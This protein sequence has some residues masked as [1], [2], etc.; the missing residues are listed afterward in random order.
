MALPVLIIDIGRDSVRGGVF[1]PKMEPLDFFTEP[2]QGA[3]HADRVAGGV[4]EAA[5]LLLQKVRVKYKGFEKVL[6]GLPSSELSVR[7]MAL[8]F[9]DRKKIKDVL[10]FELSGLLHVDTD[11]LIMDGVPLGGGHVLAVAMEKTALREYLAAFNGIG[12][13]PSWAGPALLAMPVL[14]SELYGGQGV[15]AFIS[16][17]SL[18]VTEN[19]AMKFFKPV[20]RLDNVKLGLKYVEAEGM[21][22][23]EA[24]TIGWEPD[25]LKPLMPGV[26]RIER[27]DLKGYPEEGAPI[28]AL[29][30]QLKKGLLPE[31]INLRI[32]EFEYTRDRIRQRRSLR[33]TAVFAGVVLLVLAGDLYVRYLGLSAE[34]ASYSEALRASYSRLFPGEKAA[35]DEAYLLEAKMKALGKEEAVIGG[36]VS[37]LKVMEGFSKASSPPDDKKVRLSEISIADGNVR[38]KGE[39]DSFEGANRFKEALSRDAVFKEVSLSDVKSKTGGGALFS[40]SAVLR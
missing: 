21:R 4:K 12:A 39:A 24:F 2:A 30:L 11:E 29:S 13:D 34:L 16:K 14:L 5:S 9:E 32:N 18:I 8:P 40:V 17:E 3:G 6:L 25:E 37:P 26:D 7:V 19:G 20:R 1:S 28:L 27:L 31:N 22:I 10:P 15:K 38:A 33:L 36:G 35:G 23:D